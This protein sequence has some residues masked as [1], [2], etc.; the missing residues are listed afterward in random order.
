M[1]AECREGLG[2]SGLRNNY[3]WA[4]AIM[5][6]FAI[7]C[8]AAPRV[9]LADETDGSAQKTPIE[10]AYAYIDGQDNG[11]ERYWMDGQYL[12]LYRGKPVCP[13]LA[14]G[15][16]DY[17]TGDQRLVEGVDYTVEYVDNTGVDGAYS[18]ARA[19]VTGIGGYSGTK[20]V[21]F[22]VARKLK[23][24]DACSAFTLSLTWNRNTRTAMNGSGQALD[25]A[26]APEFL[27]SGKPIMPVA[28]L[29]KS[30][31]YNGYEA[32]FY[33]APADFSVTYTDQGGGECSP[34]EPGLY[35]VHISATAGS[36][37]IGSADIPFRIVE[38]TSLNNSG[39]YG[40]PYLGLMVTG[41]GVITTTGYSYTSGPVTQ[42]DIYGLV[43][44]A[45]S[46]I[47][48]LSDGVNNLIEGLDYIV[49]AAG[50]GFTDEYVWNG[51]YSTVYKRA[52]K[53]FVITGMGDYAGNFYVKTTIKPS[54]SYSYGFGDFTVNGTRCPSEN[55]TY[56]VEVPTVYL[57][58]DGSIIEPVVENGSYGTGLIRG[59]DY[60]F[61]GFTDANGKSVESATNG[62]DLRI[63][64][65]GRGKYS[66]CSFIGAVKASDDN[67]NA[68]IDISKI[69]VA[70]L[71][72]AGSVKT[73]NSKGISNYLL[74]T[75]TPNVGLRLYQT[76]T[77]LREGEGFK[78]VK[79]LNTAGDRLT[80][81]A[82]GDESYGYKG[83]TETTYTLVDKYDIDSMVDW[84][85]SRFYTSSTSVQDGCY[86]GGIP[87]KPFV[88]LHVG[89]ECPGS[90]LLDGDSYDV[91]YLNPDGEPRSQID[92]AGE[93]TAIITGK[94]D[95]TGT[96]REKID[97]AEDPSG[98]NLADCSLSFGDWNSGKPA[99]SVSFN[100][101]E[102]VEGK[103][104]VVQYG[105]KT[106]GG[107][108]AVVK[109]AEGSRFYGRLSKT[110]G[111]T[112]FLSNN[113]SMTCQVLVGDQFSTGTYFN[114]TS[115]V[116]YACRYEGRPAEP[117]VTIQYW[118]DGTNNA[119]EVLDPSCYDVEYGNNDAPGTAWVKVTG[120]NGYSGTV[121][122]KFLILPST[123]TVAL[124][125]SPVK[126]GSSATFEAS[127][128]GDAGARLSYAWEQSTNGGKSWKA[129]SSAGDS[130]SMSYLLKEARAG[131]LFRCTV[132]ASD[133]RTATSAPVG[134]S[135][136][137]NTLLDGDAEPPSVSAAPG[138]DAPSGVSE[139]A[140][141]GVDPLA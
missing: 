33:K 49:K 43:D 10:Y 62:Q 78:L 60:E 37:F 50:G 13:K 5:L 131:Y 102:L 135:V 74:K 44:E 114:N 71:V 58:T 17:Q 54:S 130:P 3:P 66:G 84:E 137:G 65:E 61:V 96:H 22:T 123:L 45:T 75:A 111:G 125:T 19:I 12:Y 1:S 86:Y 38:K 64:F 109:P 116:S 106:N 93:W 104:Y 124:S 105:Y 90:D 25:A 27:Y 63:V 35:F 36:D 94:G 2:V 95:W 28:C 7:G 4:I 134:F 16:Y 41:D 100:S 67:E 140:V 120:K 99:V 26:S 8:I 29:Q 117:K 11:Y 139:G 59:I 40:G 31:S 6:L 121:Y 122:Q 108:Y 18:D 103:D 32:Q 81:A 97:V 87:F 57:D 34:V 128:S 89:N 20:E 77:L 52:Y 107:G 101:Q 30:G 80:V 72:T 88:L 82:Y 9:A 132:S 112:R 79:T 113:G 141:N 39:W 76:Q 70:G 69:D 118:G 91:S 115:S 119:E 55:D 127:A 92:C 85:W 14:V 56:R 47:F 133:G 46:F 21:H 15:Y 126:M 42:F 24:V 68:G 23:L 136:L 73:V 98:V 51:A 48:S 53:S 83:K 110:F 138:D 129:V